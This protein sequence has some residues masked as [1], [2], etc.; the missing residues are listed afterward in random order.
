MENIFFN[1]E[2]TSLQQMLLK[3]LIFM[4]LSGL[5]LYLIYLGLTKIMFKKNVARK[6]VNLRL[7]FLWA[8]IIYLILFNIYFFI[9]MFIEGVELF[10]W[11]KPIFYLGFMAQIIVYIV[12]II[13]FLLKRNSLDRIINEKSLN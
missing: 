7:I 13:Y 1:I 5:V 11:T 4:A 12:L 6:E 3:V 9:L 2:Y 10:Q 8:M